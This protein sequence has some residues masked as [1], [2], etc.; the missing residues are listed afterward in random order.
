MA[1]ETILRYR[2]GRF[3]EDQGAKEMPGGRIR[4][5][6]VARLVRV[7]FVREAMEENVDLPALRAAFR[8]K[9]TRRVWVGLGLVGVS[10]IIGWP[11]VGLLALIADYMREPLVVVVG[12]PVTYGLSHIVFW[13][14]SWFAG[15]R[16]VVIFRHWATRRLVERLR[17]PM[18]APPTMP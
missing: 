11:A 10:Y 18:A 15:A 6:I 5:R 2:G 8:E 9:P 17:G 16:Y 7:Q 4:A 1:P 14:G 13:V 3:N 12:G